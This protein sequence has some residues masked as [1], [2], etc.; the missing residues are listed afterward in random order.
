[1]LTFIGLGLYDEKDIK[2]FFVCLEELFKVKLPVILKNLSDGGHIVRVVSIQTDGKAN[3]LPDSYAVVRFFVKKKD[4]KNFVDFR[5]PYITVNLPPNDI[6]APDDQGRVCMDF[7]VHN[8]KLS[9]EGYKLRYRLDYFETTVNSA[10]PIYWTDLAPGK[11][12]LTVELLAP[13]GN[14]ALGL[15]SRV[16]RTFEI[17]PALPPMP[18]NQPNEASDIPRED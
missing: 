5:E 15:L 11:H 17:A 10:D 12:S 16:Q 9:A 4:L 14:P 2:V 6:V 1:M 7:L 8:A 3:P 13:S 18:E